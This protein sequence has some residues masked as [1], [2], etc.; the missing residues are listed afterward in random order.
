MRKLELID[1]ALAGGARPA[2]ACAMVQLSARTYYNYRRELTRCGST[3]DRRPQA[4]RAAPA[5]R[6]SDQYRRELVALC[7]TPEYQDLTPHEICCDQQ[8]PMAAI[9]ARRARSAAS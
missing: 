8:D 9:S 7:N 3:A 5:W 2:A 1:E 4:R 6:Y